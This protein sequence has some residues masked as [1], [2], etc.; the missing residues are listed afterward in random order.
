MRRPPRS[1][2]TDTLFPYTTL[3]R[4]LADV[5]LWRPLWI[6][7]FQRSPELY[8]AN[9]SSYRRRRADYGGLSRF[10]SCHVRLAQQYYL[11]NRHEG[12]CSD[13][14]SWR[15]EQHWAARA[16]FFSKIGR[17]SRRERVFQT[18]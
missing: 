12:R 10:T 16:K 18:V 3:F 6:D 17:A 11:F 7:S 4:S 2:R 14:R 8:S 1:T 15:E 13:S 9:G 5:R